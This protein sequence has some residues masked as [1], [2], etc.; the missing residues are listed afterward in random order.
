MNKNFSDR[1]PQKRRHNNHNHNP[2]HQNRGGG[3]PQNLAQRALD[4]NG[5]DIK[6]RGTAEHICKKYQSLAR[7]A[8]LSGNRVRA[9]GYLQYA[10]HYYRIVLAAQAQ[11]QQRQQQRQEQA[12]QRATAESEMIQEAQSQPPMDLNPQADRFEDRR[13]DRPEDRREDESFS[14]RD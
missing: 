12:Q 5:P 7:D 4:S 10:D 11:Q 13:E 14:R 8:Q 9:E 3:R 2:R 6:I 1:G